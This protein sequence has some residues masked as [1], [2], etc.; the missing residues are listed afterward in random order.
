[1]ATLSAKSSIAA[2]T[3]PLLVKLSSVALVASSVHGHASMN[4]GS[5][6][7][8][9][10]LTLDVCQRTLSADSVL[11]TEN[12][13]IMVLTEEAVHVFKRSIGCLRIPEVHDRDK[14]EVENCPDD[15]ELP[16]DAVDSDRGDFDNH[17]KLMVSTT[18]ISLEEEG[19]TSS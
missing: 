9:V 4:R 13:H 8:L 17:A 19:L 12:E 3:F 6:S 14:A 10:L 5:T 18:H 16:V 1:M 11:V 7:N 2:G 15:V